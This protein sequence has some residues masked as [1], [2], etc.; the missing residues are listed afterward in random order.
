MALTLDRTDTHLRNRVM[1]QLEQ[2]RDVDARAIGV[3]AEAGRVTLT[4]RVRSL[5]E[6]LA[7][8]NAVKWLYGVRAIVNEIRVDSGFPDSDADI[9]R[10]VAEA[11]GRRAG[12]PESVTAS[13]RDGV[14]TLEGAVKWLYQRLAAET[15][16]AYLPGVC[17]VDNR[18][19]L[20]TG[21]TTAALRDEVEQAL[22]RTAG[23]DW[24]RI[25]VTADQ[26]VVT[27]DG[28]VFSL[29]E[30]ESAERAAWA[31]PGVTRVESRLD[32]APRRW[33]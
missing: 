2:T 24:K 20:S 4:G 19:V 27:L 1:R 23:L 26:G 21:Q 8:E 30:K 12:V 10:L 29:Q 22:V 28:D 33:W 18:I 25:R 15:A 5:P 11:L 3:G 9:E 16:V 32:V 6:K 31:N 17:G 7:V 14:V 13:V